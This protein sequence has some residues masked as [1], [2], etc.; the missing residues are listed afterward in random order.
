MELSAVEIKKI[1]KKTLYKVTNFNKNYGLYNYVDG[2]N[3]ADNFFGDDPLDPG[4]FGFYFVTFECM[5]Q[6]YIR[7]GIKLHKVKLPID[8]PELKVIKSHDKHKW[9]AN[10]IILI[11]EHD[12]YK[13]DSYEKLEQLKTLLPKDVV[14]SYITYAIYCNDFEMLEWLKKSGVEMCYNRDALDYASSVGN[15]MMLDWLFYYHASSKT[16]MLY[17]HNAIDKISDH[18]KIESLEWWFDKYIKYGIELKYSSDAVDIASKN[19]Y[20]KILDWWFNRSIKNNLEFKYSEYAV[21][22]AI[23]DKNFESL[24]WWLEVHTKYNVKIKIHDSAINHAIANGHLD[25]LKWWKQSGLPINNFETALSCALINGY[26]DVLEWWKQSGMKLDISYSL[27]CDL[28]RSIIKNRVDELKNPS[29]YTIYECKY[30]DLIAVITVLC[31][32]N[33]F[34]WMRDNSLMIDYD[35]SM[36]IASKSN[37]VDILDWWFYNRNIYELKYHI[38]FIYHNLAQLS[39]DVLIWWFSSGLIN[40][41]SLENIYC[42][43]ELMIFCEYTKYIPVI[44]KINLSLDYRIRYFSYSDAIYCL[45]KSVENNKL[46]CLEIGFSLDNKRLTFLADFLKRNSTVNSLTFN[47]IFNNNNNNNNTILDDIVQYLKE[48]SQLVSLNVILESNTDINSIYEN[49]VNCIS[50]NHTLLNLHIQNNSYK[51]YNNDTVLKCKK[52]IDNM[53]ERN[54]EIHAKKI[55]VRT[56]P[57]MQEL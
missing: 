20:I 30:G 11:E 38:N 10:K 6:Y 14:S 51:H 33:V 40:E 18:G 4:T 49:F 53:L 32:V 34:D 23:W 2:I 24:N 37:K 25:I 27:K 50:T 1:N 36:E 54:N 31:N 56:K 29:Q 19:G 13:I 43:K 21:N 12:S 22:F 57:I 35:N 9:Y 26:F 28:S 46:E 17:S 16:N 55:F 47:V 15:I 44:K 45:L 52:I 3:T 7:H 48:D 42:E 39:S 5:M 8:D 41:L